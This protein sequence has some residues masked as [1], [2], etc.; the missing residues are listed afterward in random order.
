MLLEQYSNIEVA[1]ECAILSAWVSETLTS[2]AL[3]AEDSGRYSSPKQKL[4]FTV[5]GGLS[6]SSLSRASPNP[7]ELLVGAKADSWLVEANE[8]E[9][10]IESPVHTLYHCAVISGDTSRSYCNY[11]AVSDL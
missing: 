10:Q 4:A 3:S 8:N 11:S 5:A 2:H 9:R 7:L 6:R 1:V